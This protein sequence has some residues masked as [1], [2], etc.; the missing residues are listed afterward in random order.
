M[1]LYPGWRQSGGLSKSE[2]DKQYLR[3][4]KINQVM[5]DWQSAYDEAKTTNLQR[6]DEILQ[7]YN[8]RYSV[9]IEA[10]QGLGDAEKANLQ[11]SYNVLGSQQQQALLKPQ[12][13]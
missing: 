5:A 6:Y 11:H 3:T 7:G 2:W 10:L 8:N 4:Q 1:S 13:Q 12:Y 9:G